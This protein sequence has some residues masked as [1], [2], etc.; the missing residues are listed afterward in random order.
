MKRINE[1]RNL[2]DQ[3]ERWL[4]E[5]DVSTPEALK[6]LGSIEAWLRLRFIFGSRIS[7]IA[8]YAMEASLRDLDWRY[9]PTEVK[10]ELKNSVGCSSMQNRT[11]NPNSPNY[12]PFS[13]TPEAVQ[14]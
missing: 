9:L 6:T 11:K 3:M 14:K 8:L 2:G 13:K 10:L 1:M 4:R 7:I 5:A 12:T